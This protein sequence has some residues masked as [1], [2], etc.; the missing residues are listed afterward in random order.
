MY[1][2]IKLSEYVENDISEISNNL[3]NISK[4]KNIARVYFDLL[5]A[6]IY[7]LNFLPE[8]Y[9]KYIGK[10][11]SLNIKWFKIFYEV[12]NTTNEVYIYRVLSQ[13]QNYEDYL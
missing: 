11:R 7:S 6:G 3:Y 2:K 10:Y 1:Y 9:Q 12:K 13:K 8:R 5:Y 4:S